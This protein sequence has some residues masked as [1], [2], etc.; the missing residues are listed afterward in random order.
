MKFLNLFFFFIILIGCSFDNKS[1]IWKNEN[2]TEKR[3]QK[4]FKEFKN[5][6]SANQSFNEIIKLKNNTGFRI[7]KKIKNLEW[8]DKF[9]NNS[10]YYDNFSY[11]DLNK[12]IFNSKKISRHKLNETLLFYNNNAIVSD[13]KGNMIIFSIETNQVIDKFNFYKK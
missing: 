1:G 7:S 2:I 8:K 6:L 11:N 9:Y 3:D 10:N 4:A 12:L 13:K 5:L